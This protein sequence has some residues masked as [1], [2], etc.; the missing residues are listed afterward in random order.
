MPVTRQKLS[1][2][3]SGRQ[4]KVAATAS[5][6]TT[7]HTATSTSGEWDEVYIWATNSSSSDVTLTIEFGGTTSPDD[8]VEKT[9]RVNNGPELVIPGWVLQGGLV[10]RGFASSANVVTIG[11][12]VN[13]ISGQ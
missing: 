8:I 13:R 7:L 3:T 2:S 6:G 4:I 10:V 9:L 12:Y 1:A 5:S 11:G